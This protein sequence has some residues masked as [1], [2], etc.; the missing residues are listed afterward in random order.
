MAPIPGP[1]MLRNQTTPRNIPQGAE[2]SSAAENVY[3]LTNLKLFEALRAP[4]GW[5]SQNF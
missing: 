5:G 2:F 3:D 1:E 4:D